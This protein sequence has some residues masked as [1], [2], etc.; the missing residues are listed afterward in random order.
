MLSRLRSLDPALRLSLAH[1]QVPIALAGLFSLGVLFL[2]LNRLVD[3]KLYVV[4]TIGIGL[5]AGV[6]Y[7]IAYYLLDASDDSPATLWLILFGAIVFRLT[8][9]PLAPTL[10]DDI[11]RYRWDGR[12]QEA[13]LN[14]YA[15]KPSDP[16]LAH[17]SDPQGPAI[18]GRDIPS[19]YPPL[20]E[21]TYR[22]TYR[23]LSGPVAFKLPFLLADLLIVGMLAVW[24]RSTGGRNSTLAL[25]AWNPLVVV[26][27]AASG[28]NDALAT[29][30]VFAASLLIIRGRGT[31]STLLLAAGALFKVFPVVLFPFWLRRGGWPRS[32]WS[33]INLLAAAALAAVCAWPFRSACARITETLAYYESRY[34]HNNASL[35]ALLAW[36][37]G[38]TD[39]AA[40]IGV[41]IVAG[42]SLWVAVRRPD[43]MKAA[44]LLFGAI[45][46][47]TPNAFSWY[48]TW[49]VPFLCFFPNPA[50]LLLTVLQFLSYHVLIDYQASGAWHF[51][52]F[53]LW[54]TYG[55]FFALALWRCLWPEMTAESSGRP[56]WQRASFG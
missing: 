46:L 20:L 28:H 8:L 2:F 25:Y 9:F 33:W 1:R 15:V 39:I 41:G 35:Y 18:P 36:F 6:I 7:L 4:E 17:L 5:A 29:A 16:L 27:L 31:L 19:L 44:S 40:G 26:E 38:S 50:W 32:A 22:F 14:P 37:S 47:L 45:L 10:S 43:T 49:L 34:Q 53:F 48:F 3:L 24:I 13:S 52:P 12:V 11:Y 21:L 42:L 55:P 56:A 30:A 51:Q 23:Y 54:L